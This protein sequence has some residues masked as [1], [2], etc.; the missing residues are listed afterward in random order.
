M[1][2]SF[3][4][5][6]THYVLR[7]PLRS[8]MADT[9]YRG[10][11][12]VDPVREAETHIKGLERLGLDQETLQVVR[13]RVDALFKPP[14]V[15]TEPQAPVAWMAEADA[16]VLLHREWGVAVP[17]RTA[18]AFFHQQTRTCRKG[19]KG[20]VHVDG[21]YV[22]QLV[23][24]YVPLTGLVKDAGRLPDDVVTRFCAMRIGRLMLIKRVEVADLLK[25]L[26]GNSGPYA[27]GKSPPACVR[28][29]AA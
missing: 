14:E 9:E 19:V 16:I 6:N 25:V 27:V 18:R 23:D 12:A 22:R 13:Q 3:D 15:K 1:R 2:A 4:V 28:E 5:V 24:G 29:Q 21:H 17:I 20:G 8:A 10:R 7:N 11:L 26:A